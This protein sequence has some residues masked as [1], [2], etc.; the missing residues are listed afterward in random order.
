MKNKI[1]YTITLLFILGIMLLPL[2]TLASSAAIKVTSSST[3]VLVGN[4]FKVTVK[5]SSSAAMGAYNYTLSYDSSKLKLTSGD[6]SVVGWSNNN[7]TKS[8]TNT[9]TFKAVGS[10]SSKI[11]VKSYEVLDFATNTMSISLSPVTIQA[12]TQSQLE[13]T[14]SDNNYLSSLS[15]KGYNLS[16]SFNKNTLEY[17]V[18]LDPDVESIVI[19]ATKEHNKATISG[20]GTITVSEG[21]NKIEIK[22]TSQKGTTKI[23]TLI[24]TVI[25]K[26]P[27][28]VTVD[29][30]TYTIVKK[31]SILQAPETY[32][33]KEIVIEGE[34]IPSFFSEI[35][36]YNLVGL[37]ANNGDVKLYIYDST[38]NSYTLY[39]EIKFSNITFYPLKF[40][41]PIALYQKVNVIVN[42]ITIES[43]K[44][45]KDSKYALIYGVNIETGE[46][47]IYMYDESENTIQK[48]NTEHINYLE[49]EIKDKDFINKILI[50]GIIV[51]FLLISITSMIRLANRS[52]KK[53]KKLEHEKKK[54]KVIS[55]DVPKDIEKTKP[56][57]KVI[58][59]KKKN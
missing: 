42:D 20:T 44:F 13:A 34:S 16:P 18:T 5:I 41:E 21:D 1:I 57:E 36:G 56:I 8:F 30:E 52:T 47:S 54:E 53:K 4:T 59:D 12:L 31:S 10:G 17:K 19:S 15:V 43:Y 50:I 39:N 23:Y 49:E 40:K 7:S 28:N 29:N 11:S 35:T 46:E 51:E 3:S 38:N 48:F 32:E 55:K 2:P 14:Y 26:N 45:D 9:F 22:V 6:S 25:D 58:K 27:I 37:K 33:E 24:A